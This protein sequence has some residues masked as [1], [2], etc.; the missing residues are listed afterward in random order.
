LAEK[1][2]VLFGGRLTQQKGIDVLPDLLDL[3]AAD[4]DAD[5][6]E[7]LIAGSGEPAAEREL[8]DRTAGKANVTEHAPIVIDDAEMCRATEAIG[9]FAPS[10]LVVARDQLKADAVA[11][12]LR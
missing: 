10:G 12:I 6:F 4:P 5:A 9:S 2:R 3:A 11:F 1:L 8:A 7:F